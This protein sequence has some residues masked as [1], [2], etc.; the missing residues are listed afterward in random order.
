MNK[1]GHNNVTDASTNKVLHSKI[2]SA[3]NIYIFF[4][5]QLSENISTF[6]IQPVVDFEIHER[7]CDCFNHFIVTAVKI[8]SSSLVNI[9]KYY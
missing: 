4:I 5:I 2:Y 3:G 7:S 1:N 8:T 6:F 9:T